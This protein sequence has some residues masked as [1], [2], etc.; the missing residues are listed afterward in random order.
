[1]DYLKIGKA[2]ELTGQDKRLYRLLEILPG[3]LSWGT[4]F[5]LLVGSYFKPVWVAYFIIA[6]DVYWLLLVLYLGLYLLASFRKLK[7]NIK[8]DWQKKCEE[9][10]VSPFC[11]FDPDAPRSKK[12]ELAGNCLAKKGM[13]W[14][15]IIHLIIFPTYNESLEVIRSSFQGLVSDGY[16]LEKMIVVLAIEGRAGRPAEERAEAIKQEFGPKFRNFLITIHPDIIG[17][18]K[19]KGANQAWAGRKVKEEIVDKENLSYDKILVSVFDI[20]TVVQPGYFFCLTYKFL[21]VSAPYRASYQPVPVYNNN[22]WQS[23]FFARVAASSNTF[24]QMM[25][26]M[27]HEKLATYSS[28]SMTWRALAD[29]NFW[30]TTMVSE[31]SRIFWHCLL[32]Y[33]GD[34]RVEP[35]YFPVSMDVTMDETAKQTAKSLYKQQRRWGWGVENIPYLIFNTV[36]KWKEL[37]KRKIIGRILVQLYGFHSW[38]TNALIIAVIGWMPMVLGGDRFNATVLSSNL[39][40]IT[41]TLMIFAMVGLAVSAI[42]STLLLP[43]RPPRY[44]WYKNIV[45]VL[46]WLVLPFSIIIFGAIPGLEAQTRLMLG[47]YMG[48]SVT[49]KSRGD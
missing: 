38:A 20:D 41:R 13:A 17:E 10:T 27:R 18:L 49:P 6:F 42:I 14:P 22:I 5:I 36:K 4:L 31:D 9:L 30:S 29:I 15:D 23:S 48:F 44:G 11:Y 3:F 7:G 37:P 34:Y 28:H 16:P 1:M 46:Q 39:P 21:T 33:Q 2:T 32:Y 47:K 24:W 8:I 35:L 19:G 12:K 26:Q 40:L 25:Q 45:M 43:P